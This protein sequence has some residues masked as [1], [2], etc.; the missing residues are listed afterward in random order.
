M[1]IMNTEGNPKMSRAS[2]LASA[3]IVI[4]T[5]GT[6]ACFAQAQRPAAPPNCGTGKAITVNLLSP[7][8]PLSLDG[9]Y[10]TLVDY[11]QI[12][13][14][15]YDGLFKLSDDMQ[16]QPNLAVGYTRPDDVTYIFILRKGVVFHD[17]SS[18]SAA[19]VVSTF[20]RIASDDK[21]ASK[22]RTYVS[23]VKSVTEIGTHEV[24]FTLKQPDASFLRSL[25]TIIYITPKSVIDKVGNVN[26]GKSPVGTGPFTFA[27]WKQGDSIVLKANCNYWGEKTIPSQVE[28]RFIPEP[29]TQISSLMSGEIDIA[30]HVAPDLATGLKTSAVASAQSVNSNMS[31]WITMNTLKPPF[32]DKRVR[33]ALNYA[34]D[35]NAI[36]N[37]LLHGYAVPI[38]QIN[39]PTVFGYTKAVGPYPYNPDR[40]RKLLKDAGFGT[41]NPLRIEF[42]NYRSELNPVWESIAAYLNDVGIVVQTRFDSHFATDTWLGKKMLPTQIGLIMSTILQMDADFAFGLYLDGARRGIYFRTPETDAAIAEARGISDP[43]ERVTGVG[44]AR[45]PLRQAAYDKLN[46][47]MKDIAPVVFLYGTKEIYGTSKRIDWKPRSD[48][49]IYLA[50]VNK[51]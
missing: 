31:V 38:G 21:L 17:G 4:F 35:R 7:T 10:D 51:K 50:G 23:N 36:A 44:L 27:S 30:T 40:A 22:Q 29:A 5:L 1:R 37:Q 20:N 19:D 33:Q 8:Q 13:R 41:G 28:F 18:F 39:P 16:V 12:S 45:S 15:L 46:V 2:W 9:N 43:L 48:G 26:F 14:N 24:K 49:A 6:G 11:A 32:S 34:V 3:S 42:V 47:R 25:A